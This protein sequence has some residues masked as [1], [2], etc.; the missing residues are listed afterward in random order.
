MT[1]LSDDV[2]VYGAFGLVMSSM[3]IA[4]F[5]MT[6]VCV[7][8]LHTRGLRH[9]AFRGAFA[10]TVA[11]LV[12]RAL[13]MPLHRP[14]TLAGAASNYCLLAAMVNAG[15][16]AWHLYQ[17]TAWSPDAFRRRETAVFFIHI[18]SSL[19]R[20]TLYTFAL[21][22][23]QWTFVGCI[24]IIFESIRSGL[25][26]SGP[27]H[28]SN[29]NGVHSLPGT[30]DPCPICFCSTKSEIVTLSPCNH[31]C[32]M[33]CM[34]NVRHMTPERMLKCHQCLGTSH[35]LGMRSILF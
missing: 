10:A 5:A 18:A 31:M 20:A 27:I 25:R 9:D 23:M 11:L 33:S 16:M 8:L 34:V 26:F 14:A 32:C 30:L 4:L 12:A 29:T 3:D 19:A 24:Y 7:H 13:C 15:M 2:I 1:L 22:S 21:F 35:F 28:L 17:T 6:L